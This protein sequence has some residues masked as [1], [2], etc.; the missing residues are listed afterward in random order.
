MRAALQT[1]WTE[2][3]PSDPPARVTRDWVLVGLLAPTALI[4]YFIRRPDLWWGASALAFALI[5]IFGLLYRRTHAFF[6]TM[7]IFLI[8]IP[9]QIVSIAPG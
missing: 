4:E 5:S 6:L 1:L 8:T 3:R 9:I 7:S 2:P